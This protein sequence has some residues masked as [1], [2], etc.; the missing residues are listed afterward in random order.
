[1]SAQD[2]VSIV[3]A[4]YDAFNARDFERSS[5]LAAP[6]MEQV[7]V[8]L[9]ARFHGPAG[10]GEYLRI[11]ASAFPDAR[12]ELTSQVASAG[13]VA[14]EWVFRGTHTGALA[15]AGMMIPPT[16]RTLE[17]KGVDLWSV[18]A[19]R[20]THHRG[21]PDVLAMIQQ[22]NVLPPGTLQGIDRRAPFDLVAIDLENASPEQNKAV[23]VR[24]V[25]EVLN[26]GHGGAALALCAPSFAWHGGASGEGGIE[27]MRQM[28]TTFRS[29]FPDLRAAP[30]EMVAQADLVVVRLGMRGTHLGEFQGVGATGNP[31]AFTATNS[32]RVVDGKIVEEWW[33]MDLLALMQQIGAV[34]T[35]IRSRRLPS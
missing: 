15:G 35:M 19:G 21:Y 17:M 28:L 13:E 31:V 12:L 20:L 5:A 22:L 7:I 1:M 29:G 9:D 14:V 30:G 23:V 8:P 11:W 2:E 24:Y 34:R 33:Q 4:V 25:E 3:R 26:R 6:G 10:L 18:E 16:G 32:Y 27:E